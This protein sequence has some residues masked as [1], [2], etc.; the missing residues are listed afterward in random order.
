[1]KKNE[2][3]KVILGSI[4]V[5]FALAIL[6]AILVIPKIFKQEPDQN[7][8]TE[9][10]LEEVIKASTLS[11]YETVYNGVVTVKNQAKP[12]KIDYYISYSATVK[13][14]LNF[15][16]IVIKKDD[17]DK[18]IIVILPEITLQDPI[19]PIEEIDYIIIN[20]KLNENGLIA[21]AYNYAIQDAKEKS[22]KQEALLTYA[23]LNAENLIKGLLSPF[24]EQ[25]DNY[26]IE[27]E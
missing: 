23:A 19:I 1:M 17:I 2:K 4:I 24:V 13:A 10:T 25:L 9:A 11:T 15:K 27:F 22:A 26:T 16:D 12:E 3:M 18:K 20:K 6:L 5:S 21:T 8:I 7:T 14:G